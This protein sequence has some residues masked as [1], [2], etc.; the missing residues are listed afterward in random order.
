MARARSRRET[1]RTGLMAP[2]DRDR[3]ARVAFRFRTGRIARSEARSPPRS[4]AE[5]RGLEPVGPR[6]GLC[7]LRW[8]PGLYLGTLTSVL[9]ALGCELEGTSLI[10]GREDR[11][12][13]LGDPGSP[14][15]RP[16]VQRRRL[17][18]GT[19]DVHAPD[20]E[21]RGGPIA[22]CRYLRGSSARSAG[23]ARDRV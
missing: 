1:P 4:T 12:G 16:E 5:A 14:E 13:N 3:R 6:G 18:P 22:I 23:L 8:L 9:G 10:L 19:T 2:P 17:R 7:L 15:Q 20:R 11:E 21:A